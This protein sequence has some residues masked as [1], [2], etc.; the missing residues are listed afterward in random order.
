MSSSER[1]P[2]GSEELSEDLIYEIL[3]RLPVKSL[4][5][6]KAVSRPWR[7]L[8]S[9]P[10]FVKSHQA[11]PGSYAEATL[12]ACSETEDDLCLFSLV[13]LRPS[14][15]VT[16]LK[17]PYFK[18]E[19]QDST[20]VG[21][22]R[23]VV[24]VYVK[25]DY[26]SYL[27][28]DWYPTSTYLW[29]PS[30]MQY[31]LIPQHPTYSENDKDVHLGFG[32]DPVDND[33]KVVR[34]L[35]SQLASQVYSANMN[36]WRQTVPKPTDF[37]LGSDD[38]VCVDGLLCWTGSDRIFS[39]DLNKEVFSSV[40]Y[41]FLNYEHSR[42]CIIDFNNSIAVN[43]IRGVQNDKINLWTLD[44]IECLRGGGVGVEASWTLMLCIDANVWVHSV[45]TYFNSGDFLLMCDNPKW[46]LFN[47]DKRE[48]K[49]VSVPTFHGGIFKY[50]ETL[51]S[52]NGFKQVKWNAHED[53]K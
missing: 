1:C 33:F 22:D 14:Q 12:V 28:E 17:D 27:F 5:R 37:H 24:C 38:K 15:L 47:S 36:V 8:I 21:S 31:K 34:F 3:L 25:H 39:F 50:T 20:I 51:V 30:T 7:C 29:N 4:L 46:V 48:S 40:A 43:I 35:S 6:F 53:D 41:N 13:C 11:R 16:E 42:P 44:D 2:Q 26:V 10:G 23:G 9:S 32:F 19:F 49:H 45:R 18:Q 52:I